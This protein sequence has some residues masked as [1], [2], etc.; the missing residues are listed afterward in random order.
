MPH[1]AEK[2]RPTRSGPRNTIK[3]I[4][5]ENIERTDSGI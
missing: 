1:I 4:L 2:H 5:K 3:Y